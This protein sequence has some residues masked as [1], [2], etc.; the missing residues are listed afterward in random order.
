MVSNKIKQHSHKV[1]YA[2]VAY[3]LLIIEQSVTTLIVGQAGRG[4]HFLFLPNLYE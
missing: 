4:V 2:N 1:S 3:I